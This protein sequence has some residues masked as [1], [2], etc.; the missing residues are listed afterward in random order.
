LD[1]SLPGGVR[2]AV[3]SGVT[4]NACWL[5]RIGGSVLHFVDCNIGEYNA[6]VCVLRT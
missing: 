5:G 4:N 3:R 6:L 2:T 1:G